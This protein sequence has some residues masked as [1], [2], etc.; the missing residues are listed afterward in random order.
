MNISKNELRQLILK[1]F[2]EGLESFEDM[3]EVYADSVVV[4]FFNREEVCNET[5]EYPVQSPIPNYYEHISVLPRVAYV[6]TPSIKPTDN[7]RQFVTANGD[8]GTLS[9]GSGVGSWSTGTTAGDEFTDS[10]VPPMPSSEA[11]D[12]VIVN[13]LDAINDPSLTEA[14]KLLDNLILMPS[15]TENESNEPF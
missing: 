11:S 3:K 10:V 6:N 13:F 5:W 4:N 1:A 15:D 7:P 8:V 2:Q 12:S 9:V 14:I